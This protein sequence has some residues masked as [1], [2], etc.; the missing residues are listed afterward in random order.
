MGEHA[1]DMAPRA[2]LIAQIMVRRTDDLLADQAI[3]WV[4]PLRRKSV[5]PLSQVQ[6]DAL[7]AGI[8]AKRPQAKERAQLVLGVTEAL[9]NFEGLCPGRADFGNGTPGKHQRCRKRGVELHL[10]ARVPAR[11]GCDRGESPLDPAAALLH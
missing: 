7:R 9:R 2:E 1:L 8:D 4:R 10:A 6:S 5:E 3:V 11:P